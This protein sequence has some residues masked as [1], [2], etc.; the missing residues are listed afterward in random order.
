MNVP[1]A[2]VRAMEMFVAG[3]WSWARRSQAGGAVG[4]ALGDWA[5]AVL[6]TINPNKIVAG[7]AR[8]LRQPLLVEFKIPPLGLEVPRKANSAA[9]WV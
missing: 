8:R 9:G 3:I 7:T 1:A 4:A 2:T 6:V 5:K